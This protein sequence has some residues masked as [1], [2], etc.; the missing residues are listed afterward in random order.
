MATKQRCASIASVT[1]PA[2]CVCMICKYNLFSGVRSNIAAFLFFIFISF[3]LFDSTMDPGFLKADS[4]NL[5]LVDSDMINNFYMDNLQFVS[6]EVRN[7]KTK[8][9]V[10]ILLILIC[11]CFSE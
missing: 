5:P 11:Y 10:I 8:R 1:W 2:V 4:D 3:V 6:S 7:V 9:Y